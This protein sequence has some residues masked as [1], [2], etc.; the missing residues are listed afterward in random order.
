[1]QIAVAPMHGRHDG[2]PEQRREQAQCKL[3]QRRAVQ[4]QSAQRGRPHHQH[5]TDTT[6]QSR[7][8]QPDRQPVFMQAPGRREQHRQQTDASHRYTGGTR[9][10][11][12]CSGIHGRS[13][14][15]QRGCRVR[16]D[17][18]RINRLHAEPLGLPT[19]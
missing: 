10:R 15:T 5:G 17:P 12:E 16:I 2:S 14:V 6:T 18:D 9:H 3:P 11:D 13:D 7:G 8:D 19:R 1:M 4:R